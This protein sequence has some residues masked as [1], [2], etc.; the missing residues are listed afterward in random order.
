MDKWM[1]RR[2]Y[3]VDYEFPLEVS[4]RLVD[5]PCA[6]QRRGR[7]EMLLLQIHATTSS[8]FNVPVELQACRSLFIRWAQVSRSF[9]ERKGQIA[10]MFIL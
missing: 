2:V 4:R 9:G 5:H 3:R 1:L 8:M 7:G 6:S 10:S